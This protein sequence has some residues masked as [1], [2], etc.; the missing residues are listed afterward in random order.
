MTCDIIHLYYI[1]KL[2]TLNQNHFVFCLTQSSNSLLFVNNNIAFQHIYMVHVKIIDD[3]V[4][5]FCL[6]ICRPGSITVLPWSL[7][8][9][10]KKTHSVS[11][12]MILL[13]SR[14]KNHEVSRATVK[15]QQWQKCFLLLFLIQ[16][17]LRFSSYTFFSATVL[18]QPQK[19]SNLLPSPWQCQ[20]TTSR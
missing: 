3:K 5:T 7:S 2:L 20:G 14:K 1:K 19:Q 17:I 15:S 16:A 18:L 11:M 12:T 8:R 6:I 10:Q 4:M 13:Q 9:P